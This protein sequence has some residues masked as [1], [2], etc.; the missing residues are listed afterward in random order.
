MDDADP[1]CIYLRRPG[2]AGVPAGLVP[3]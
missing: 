2:P 3:L 1:L